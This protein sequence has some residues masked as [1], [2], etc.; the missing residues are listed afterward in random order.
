MADGSWALRVCNGAAL[1]PNLER[2][3]HEIGMT[4]VHVDSCFGA[5]ARLQNSAPVV[6]LTDDVL[7]DGTWAD[8]LKAA[9]STPANP[10]VIVVSRLPDIELYLDVLEAGAYDFIVPPIGPAELGHIV[11]NV[12]RK[13]SLPDKLRCAKAGS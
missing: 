8:V 9:A 2:M 1:A 13:V 6:I 3:L 7:P 11:G 5:S 10:P 12:A 4:P